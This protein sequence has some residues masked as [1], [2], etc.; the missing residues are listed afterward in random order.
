M[1]IE[2]EG[3][4]HFISIDERVL[5]SCSALMREFKTFYNL[6]IIEYLKPQKR[7]LGVATV[8]P[9]K[10]FKMIGL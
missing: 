6:I 2:G 5:D 3:C 1:I 7:Q 8:S 10:G 9:N 4:R